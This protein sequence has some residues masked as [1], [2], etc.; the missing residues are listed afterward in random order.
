MSAFRDLIPRRGRHRAAWSLVVVIAVIA[1]TISGLSPASAYWTATGSGTATVSTG[2]LATPVDVLVPGSATAEVPIAWSQGTDGVAPEGYFV[3]RQSG[4][5]TTAAC[6]S[7]PTVLIETPG[8]TD[9]SVPAGTYTYTVTAV[10]QSWTASGVSSSSVTVANDALPLGAARSFSVLSG[11]TVV[12]TG[13]TSVSGDLG[14]SSGGSIT[15]FPPGTVGGDI[16]P[17]DALADQ[18][19][20]ALSA[21]YADLSG[22]TADDEIVDNLGGQTYTPG[23]YHS[24]AALALTGTVVLDAGG[25]PN[26]IFVFHT[27]AAFSTTAASV[28]TLANGA[29]ASNVYWVVSGTADTG[30]SSSLSGNIIANGAITLGADTRLIGRALSLDAVTMASAT[31]RFT[32]GPAP[33]IAIDGGTAA[34]TK[35]TTPTISGTSNAPVSSAITVTVASQSLQTTVGVDGQW[36]T[37]TA[38]LPAGVHTV[39]AKVRDSHGNGNSATQALTVEVNPVRP[40]LGAASTYSTLAGTSIV[41]TGS[42]TLSGDI[43][44]SPGTSITGFPPGVHAGMLHAGDTAAATAQSDLLAALDDVSARAPHT[45]IVDDIGGKTFH[46]G[47]HHAAAALALTGTVTLDAEGDPDAVFIFVTDAAF[48]TAADSHVALING[49]QASNVFWVVAGDVGTGANS[50]LSGSVLAHGAITLGTATALTGQALSRDAVILDGAVASGINPRLA[51]L[52]QGQPAT[53]SSV[54]ANTDNGADKA[55]DGIPGTRWASEWEIDPQWIMVD[56][57]QQ[58]SIERV[59]LFWERAH[60][61]AYELQVSD[62]GTDGWQT[63]YSTTTGTEGLASLSVEGQGRFVRMMG[64]VRSNGYGYS[65]YEFQVFGT[66]V[67]PGAS[68]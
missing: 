31:I 53:A 6:A 21:A 12:S 60:A 59:D 57:G 36:A 68:P 22:R 55:F 42:T 25:D 58:Y 43:G 41:S 18:A 5:T 37:T 56:L 15:G 47:V 34:V 4:A 24:T 50:S 48:N 49:A 3:T 38:A 52:S 66:P 11:T 13:A 46:V 32:E 67:Q 2:T 33:T 29:L 63:I 17:G 1:V 27:D 28:V 35:S 7:S 26:A 62:T 61:T 44:V 40:S 45:E 10:L 14:V 39:T 23:V 54:E 19:N 16:H 30:E 65:L 20:S 64:T 9:T 51:L 8:C